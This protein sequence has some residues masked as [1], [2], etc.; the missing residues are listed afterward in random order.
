[1]RPQP[2]VMETKYFFANA[3]IA[4]LCS[5]CS[6]DA[7]KIGTR[8]CNFRLEESGKQ[9]HDPGFACQ[10]RAISSVHGCGTFLYENLFGG[11]QVMIDILLTERRG[12]PILQADGCFHMFGFIEFLFKTSGGLVPTF[13]VIFLLLK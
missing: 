5:D 2:L 9:P 11:M 10:D 6:D 3:E 8:G 4:D 7:G 12:W 13:S 1:M